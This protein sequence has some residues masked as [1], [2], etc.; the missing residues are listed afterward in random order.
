[1]VSEIVDASRRAATLTKQLLAFS[2]QSVLQVRSIDLNDA[3]LDTDKLLKRLIGE[4]IRL[5]TQLCLLPS[6]IR[7]DASQIGQVLMNLVV[8]ARDAMPN[9]GILTIST[10]QVVVGESDRST[11]PTVGVGRFMKLVVSDSGIG[12]SASHLN[13]IFEPFFTTKEVGKGTGLGLSVV[14]GIVSQ[15]GGYVEVKSIEGKAVLSPCTFQPLIRKLNP[16]TGTTPSRWSLW[17]GEET[18]RSYSLKT[19]MPSVEWLVISL[20]R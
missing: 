13:R 2:R 6:R 11:H 1:M 4:N 10:S 19:R 7:A 14:F 17:P 12:I 15:S 16:S 9:G 18:K 5:D 3:V 8:N 20:F